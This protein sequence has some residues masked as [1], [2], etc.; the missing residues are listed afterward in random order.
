LD[1]AL[2]AEVA[3]PATETERWRELLVI[4]VDGDAVCVHSGAGI[5]DVG[6]D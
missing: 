5:A 4:E 1:G 6:C 3:A 2:L